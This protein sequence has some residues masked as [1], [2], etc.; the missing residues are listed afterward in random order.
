MLE[1]FLLG[2]FHVVVDGAPITSFRSDKV[3]ALLAYLALEAGRPQRREVLT[4]L[5]WPDQS[6][7]A[8]RL[9]L[10]QAL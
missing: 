6:E 10:R 7:S 4:T 3:R 8:A 1:L 5:L 2:S 9:N